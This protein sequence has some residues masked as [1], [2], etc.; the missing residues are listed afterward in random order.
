MGPSSV[1]TL[2][3]TKPF[4]NALYNSRIRGF[5][6]MVAPASLYRVMV[7][8]YS[9]EPGADLAGTDLSH[10]DLTEMYL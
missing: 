4:G 2:P 5:I 3:S 6:Q 1:Q 7:N 10:A 8:G 9:I